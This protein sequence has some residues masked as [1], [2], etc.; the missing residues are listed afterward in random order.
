MDPSRQYPDQSRPLAIDHL[1]SIWFQSCLLPRPSGSRSITV[2]LR[3]FQVRPERAA[4]SGLPAGV[5]PIIVI[6]G[7]IIFGM[8]FGDIAI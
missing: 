3:L 6:P 5:L 1:V 2:D 8:C 7:F 4:M